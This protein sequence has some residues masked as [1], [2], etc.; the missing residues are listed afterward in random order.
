MISIVC[1]F[2]NEERVIE[3]S[4][5]LMLQNLESL[6]VDWELIIVDDGSTDQSL[7]MAKDIASKNKRLKVCGYDVNRGRGYAIRHGVARAVG[8]IVVTTEI[9]S[10]WGDNIVHN[11]VNEFT[12]YPRSDVIIASP[13]LP[14]GGY[15]NVP[16]YRVCL[17][18]VGN[19]IIRSGLTYKITMN[20]GMTRAYKRSSFMKLPLDENG[21]EMHLEVINKSLAFG[22]QIR[23]IPAILEWRDSKFLKDGSVKRKSSSSTGRLIKSHMLFSVIVAPFRYLYLI[24]AVLMMFGFVLFL[25]NLYEYINRGAPII[26]NSFFS[27][28]LTFSSIILF[29]VAV[30]AQQNR[31]IQR[32][33]WHLR[34]QKM[35]DKK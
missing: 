11:L 21:K 22:Y 6:E 30:L 9:D 31:A 19:Y 17:S 16:F 3:G 32:E 34:S 23:E 35:V 33:L 20:T 10:S 2:F 26:E 5:S 14:G 7:F 12:K 13:H 15:K 27:I 24:S 18:A 4:I 28:F 29:G 25:I 8:D 1:P